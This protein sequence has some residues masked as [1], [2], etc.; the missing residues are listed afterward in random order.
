MDIKILVAAHKKYWMAEDLVYMPLHVGAEGKEPLGYTSDNTGD[1]ISSKNP[2]YCELTGLYWAWKNLHA[3]YVGLCHYRRYFAHSDSP[4][5]SLEEKKQ[6]ILKRNDYEKLLQSYDVIVPFRSLW[7]RH[8]TTKDQ[9][10]GSHYSKDLCILRQVIQ[11]K[12]PDYVDAFE[13]VMKRHSSH[14]LNM[15]VIKKEHFDRYCEWLFSILFEVEKRVD[16]S[17]YD[18][19]QARIFGFMSE[20]LVDVWLCNEKMRIKEVPVVYLEDQKH[21]SLKNRVKPYFCRIVY[22]WLGW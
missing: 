18:T 17:D 16:I 8:M 3:D 22:S 12:Q 7:G 9:Y 19:Y 20:R 10:E 1:N 2:N 5:A 6:L 4:N 15:F 14:C 11:E 13:V 21:V